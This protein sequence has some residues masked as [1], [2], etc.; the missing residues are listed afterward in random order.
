MREADA[1]IS[2]ARSGGVAIAY[3]VVG[4]GDVDLVFVPPYVSNLVYGWESPYRRPFYDRLARSFRLILFD[5]RGT[6][7]SDHGPHFAALDTRMEDLRAVLDACR[8]SDPVVLASHEGCS[9]AALYAATYPERTRALVL[10][11]PL[12]RGEAVDDPERVH[13]MADLRER[14]GTQAFSDEILEEGCPTLYEDADARRWFANWQ[15]VGASPADAYA[16]NRAFVETDLT[17]VLPAI[18]VPTLVLYRRAP[19][20]GRIRQS[21]SPR[22]FPARGRCVSPAGTTTRS[23]SLWTLPTR[24]NASSAV[25][26]LRSF[27]RAS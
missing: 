5:K 20:G 13:K 26:R 22:K 23:S 10:F 17:D 24:S 2:Y 14:W 16:L 3:M 7:L 11:H 19:G 18:R 21:R 8:A 12:V 6:G 4:A 9:M 25:K 15:R 1:E 27:P